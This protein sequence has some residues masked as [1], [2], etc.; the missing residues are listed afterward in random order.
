M[1]SAGIYLGRSNTARKSTYMQIPRADRADLKDQI[2]DS[3]GSQHG[4]IAEYC[5]GGFWEPGYRAL[6]AYSAGWTRWCGPT[7]G[8]RTLQGSFGGDWTDSSQK[9]W[10]QFAAG[11][12]RCARSVSAYVV[13]GAAAADSCIILFPL[14]I[15]SACVCS[16][17]CTYID[18]RLL[19]LSRKNGQ[20]SRGETEDNR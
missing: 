1:T 9:L 12:R 2:S 14:F 7:L 8:G 3:C 15:L 13:I 6:L 10:L 5:K 18:I 20:P 17:A 4:S 19:Y 16:T 11:R